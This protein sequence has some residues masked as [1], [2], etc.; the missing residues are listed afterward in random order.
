MNMPDLHVMCNDMRTAEQWFENLDS[1]IY[2]E[3]ENVGQDY[4]M[5][6][7]F[8]SYEAYQQ[9]KDML[10]KLMK[11]H[12]KP[13]LLH[14]YP[15]GINYYW[16][17]NI[18][19][20]ILDDM[21]RAREIGTVQIDIGNAKRFGI[22]YMD[23]DAQKKY[24]IILHCAVIGTIERYLYMLMDKAVQ[25]EK[26]SE[27]GHMPVWIIPEQVRLATVSESQN[28]RAKELADK[29]QQNCI[30]VGIDDRIETVG[31]KVRQAKQDWCSYVIVIGENEE[32][33]DVFEVYDR[34]KNTNVKMS[35]DELVRTIKEQTA[36]KPFR[37]LYMPR[38]LS[39]RVDFVD[40]A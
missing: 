34:Q 7:N 39:R 23:V 12:N 16:T 15:E 31:K 35:M 21:K 33:S 2:K 30:R 36:D 38:E 11:V 9:H 18:E 13:A 5:L 26:G 25:M 3:A 37:P 29:I 1:R 14:F 32:T 20:H 40:Q 28:A 8:S 22:Q 27:I 10:M 19:Y 24:P 4:E 17:V 6:V